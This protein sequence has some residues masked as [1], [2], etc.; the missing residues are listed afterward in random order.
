MCN[1]SNLWILISYYC[2]FEGWNLHIGHGYMPPKIVLACGTLLN[3]EEIYL[4]P[5]VLLNGR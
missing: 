4:L 1:A 3:S 2:V 5:L